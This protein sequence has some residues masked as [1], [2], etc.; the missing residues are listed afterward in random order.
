MSMSVSNCNSAQSDKTLEKTSEKPQVLC[1]KTLAQPPYM[2]G[3]QYKTPLLRCKFTT[4]FYSNKK[5]KLQFLR[6]KIS[7]KLVNSIKFQGK[8]SE[9]A[10]VLGLFLSV[11]IYS[12]H[13]IARM[14]TH[15][16]QKLS[17]YRLEVRQKFCNNFVTGFKQ[18]KKF[19][20]M[21]KDLFLNMNE[22]G[23]YFGSKPIRTVHPTR[24]NIVPSCGFGDSNHWF[25][26]C[27]SVASEGTKL[28]LLVIFI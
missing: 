19:E 28:L 22:T 1:Y 2:Q 11:A 23:I 27:I 21:L 15:T 6:K 13:L 20:F 26:A 9:K 14:R 10:I 7:E 3:L 8:G 12:Y 5:P 16:G 4:G 18:C 17:G 25:T 24:S